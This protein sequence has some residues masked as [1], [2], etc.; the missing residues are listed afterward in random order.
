[1]RDWLWAA[2]EALEARARVPA[3]SSGFPT[4]FH[5]LDE[6]TGGFDPGALVALAGRPGSGKTAFGLTVASHLA[7]VEQRAVGFFSLVDTPA[8]LTDDLVAGEAR[9]ER[10]AVPEGTHP[11]RTTSRA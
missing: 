2:F 6:L 11:R 5:D 3:S 9:V 4:G 7:T 1:M 10:L 8:A